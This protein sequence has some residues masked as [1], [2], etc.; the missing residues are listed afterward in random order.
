MEVPPTTDSGA[1]GAATPA[2]TAMGLA[3]IGARGLDHREAMPRVC[4]PAQRALGRFE[5][6]WARASPDTAATIGQVDS[7]CDDTEDDLTF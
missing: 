7:V 3:A 6:L 4:H 1:S 2:A 5:S